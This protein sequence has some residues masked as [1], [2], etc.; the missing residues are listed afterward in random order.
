MVNGKTPK[1]IANRYSLQQKISLG[2]MTTVYKGRDIVS[3][4]PIAIKRVLFAFGCTLVL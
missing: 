4:N 2:G 3:D 1:I